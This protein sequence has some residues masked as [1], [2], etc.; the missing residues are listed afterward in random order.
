MKNFHN[1]NISSL[2]RFPLIIGMAMSLLSVFHVS[3]GNIDVI[4]EKLLAGSPRICSMVLD[5]KSEAASLATSANLPDPELEGEYL[6]AP[7]GEKDRWGVSLGWSLDWPGV[8]AARKRAAQG[9]VRKSEAAEAVVRRQ[10]LIEIKRLLLDYVL[11]SS[12]VKLLEDMM[13]VNDS[14]ALLAEK[15]F[16]G[17]EMTRLDL[18]KLRIERLSLEEAILTAEDARMTAVLSLTSIHGRD[19]SAILSGLDVAFPEVE[20]PDKEQLSKVG[21]SPAELEAEAALELARLEGMVNTKE[22][23]PSLSLAYRHA[24][25]DGNHFNGGT[26]GISIPI[27]SGRGKSSASRAE[28]AAAEYRLESAHESRVAGIDAALHRLISLVDRAKR[29]SVLLEEADDSEL[30]MKAY[31]KKVITLIDYLNE[32][33][34]FLEARLNRL[35]IL[36]SLANAYLDLESYTL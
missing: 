32:R 18:A 31:E 36:H 5:N 1:F 25:E 24:F 20:I 4:A 12:R 34:Y 19:C 6:A 10:T 30:L 29:L 26:L 3:A 21:V 33:N 16:R 7:A 8:Y 23:L 9:A 22:S 13:Q 14:I 2:N 27:F 35:D 28:I 11:A 15:G 17:G